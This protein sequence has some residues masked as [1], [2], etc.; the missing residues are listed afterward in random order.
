MKSGYIVQGFYL[1]KNWYDVDHAETLEL[2][3]A[4]VSYLKKVNYELNNKYRIIK[5][6]IIEEE[7]CG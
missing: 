5:R 4:S 7:V 3:L 6:T 1:G 2:A